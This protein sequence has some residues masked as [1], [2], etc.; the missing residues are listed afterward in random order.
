MSVECSGT[1][2]ELLLMVESTFS[3][4]HL[5]GGKLN[6]GVVKGCVVSATVFQL[7]VQQTKCKQCSAATGKFFCGF[8]YTDSHREDQMHEAI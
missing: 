3:V 8:H 2:Q 7:T 5:H 4:T 1:G 6:I